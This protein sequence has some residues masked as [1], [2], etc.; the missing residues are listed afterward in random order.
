MKRSSRLIPILGIILLVMISATPFA[1]AQSPDAKGDDSREMAR[2]LGMNPALCQG[3]QTQI[4]RVLEVAQSA[5]SPEDKVARLAESL[6]ESVKQMRQSAEQDPEMGRIVKQYLSI[7]EGLLASARESSF[8][9]E[10]KQVAPEAK[11]QLQ[12]L[13]IMTT[14]YV[15]LVKIMCPDLKL[16]DSLKP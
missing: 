14:M 2:S 5:A 10:T 9:S 12:K 7:I 15:S 1:V 11:E 3:I 16:P 4:D 13:K 6:A 8:G